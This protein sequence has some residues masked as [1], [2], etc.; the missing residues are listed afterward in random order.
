M[1]GMA[2]VVCKLNAQV[3]SAVSTIHSQHVK[4]VINGHNDAPSQHLIHQYTDEWT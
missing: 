4:N 1:D 2:T 3:C